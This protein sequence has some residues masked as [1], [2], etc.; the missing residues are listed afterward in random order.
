MNAQTSSPFADARIKKGRGGI[1]LMG[2]VVPRYWTASAPAKLSA[3]IL[4]ADD[5]LSPR[6]IVAG[7]EVRLAVARRAGPPET[8]PKNPNPST[9][10]EDTLMIKS[11]S[12]DEFIEGQETEVVVT[13]A[14]ELL[15][16]EEGEIN[17]GANEGRGNGYSI[18]G[19]TRVKIG[20]GEVVL[21]ARVK[22]MRTGNLPFAKIFVNL[23]EYPHRDRWQ[24]LAN[25]SHAVGVR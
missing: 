5:A 11:V 17:L 22:P 20:T 6:R 19:K 8:A 2:K 12:P 23:S 1:K 25:D 10:Y 3:H 15:S 9:V 4:V 7:D 16:R 24:P 13:V 21:S 18:I 14:Y